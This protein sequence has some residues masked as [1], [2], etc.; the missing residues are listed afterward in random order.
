MLSLTGHLY[1]LLTLR[2]SLM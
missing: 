1:F 2:Q